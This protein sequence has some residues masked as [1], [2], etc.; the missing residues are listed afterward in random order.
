M[1]TRARCE[2]DG[3]IDHR[4]IFSYLKHVIRGFLVMDGKK[5]HVRFLILVL[6]YSVYYSSLSMIVGVPYYSVHGMVWY[7]S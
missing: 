3:C 4:C 7:G 5:I 6:I 1:M 2:V